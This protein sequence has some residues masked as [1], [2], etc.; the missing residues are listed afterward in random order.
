MAFFTLTFSA[1]TIVFGFVSDEAVR[2]VLLPLSLSGNTDTVV[3]E[4]LDVDILVRVKERRRV[5]KIDEFI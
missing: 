1:G 5:G 2:F 3:C 4:T